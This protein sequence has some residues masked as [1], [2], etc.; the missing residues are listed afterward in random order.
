MPFLCDKFWSA[1]RKEW[2]KEFCI[3]YVRVASPDTEL[4]QL[5]RAVVVEVVTRKCLVF[6]RPRPK[7]NSRHRHQHSR[8]LNQ[9]V[10]W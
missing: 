9:E 6:V 3:Q 1:R 4:I 5:L 7:T 10:L 2:K 8:R